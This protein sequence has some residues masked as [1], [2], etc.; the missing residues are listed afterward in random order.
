MP[1]IWEQFWSL[2][3]WIEIGIVVGLLVPLARA[4]LWPTLA[5][6]AGE[7]AKP[8]W[9]ERLSWVWSV[10]KPYLGNLAASTVIAFLL[11]MV[12]RKYVVQNPNVTIDETDAFFYGYFADTVVAKLSGRERPMKLPMVD[13]ADE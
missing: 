12:L 7:E 1:P 11:F 6:G 8:W 2:F 9:Q 3:P 10:A 4:K 5:V 13:P